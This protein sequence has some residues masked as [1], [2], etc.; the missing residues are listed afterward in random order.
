MT[1]R[2]PEEDP[3]GAAADAGAAPSAR[4]S[5]GVVSRLVRF[6]SLQA[7]NAIAPL[8]V[9]PV[10]ISIIGPSGWVG[11]ANGLG[12]GAAAAVAVGLAWPITGPPRVAGADA[13][14][15]R[16]VL[17]ES[18][19]MRGIVFLPVAGVA[20]VAAALLSPPGT[21]P[22]LPIA[23]AL[24]T[25]LSGLSSSW[26]FIGRARAS[27]IA[28]YETV[29]RLAATVL[30]IPAVL[31]TGQPL[32]YPALLAL[33]TL[34]G[35]TASV[36]RETGGRGLRAA[37]RPAWAGIAAQAPLGAAGLLSTGSSA[38]AVPVAT[39]SGAAVPQVGG[40]AAAVRLRGMAQ[41]GI[42]AGTSALQGWV[43]EHGPEVLRRRARTALAVNGGLGAAAGLVL[44]LAAPWVDVLIFGPDVQIS[45]GTAA[46]LGVTCLFYALSASLSH[47]VLGPSGRSRT[48]VTATC[49]SSLI[50]TPTIFALAPLYGAQGAMASVALGEGLTVLIQGFA[51]RRVL[52]RPTSPSA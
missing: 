17:N 30:T 9:L 34:G 37:I 20:A 27:G 43:A 11:L 42:G 39:A 50:A 46:I 22:V 3:V 4:S 29:P 10:V 33:A 44:A 40:F 52:A 48:I 38:L 19:V 12:I 49:V 23:M 26:Y 36:L 13:A 35:T 8:L 24:A 14:T 5:P 7:A 32:L 25:A 1:G 31:W 2:P 41:A 18:V 47:H 28:R 16:A 45:P 6:G 51:A 21:D 15:A